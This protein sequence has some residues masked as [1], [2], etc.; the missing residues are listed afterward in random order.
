MATAI[1]TAALCAVTSCGDWHWGDGIGALRI[2]RRVAEPGRAAMNRFA[3]YR[4][5]SPTYV[6]FGERVAATL[7]N[8]EGRRA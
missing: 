1:F 5:I 6:L 3:V 4:D 7:N 2:S 8:G